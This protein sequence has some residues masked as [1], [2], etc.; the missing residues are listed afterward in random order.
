MGTRMDKVLNILPL[1][2]LVA[3]ADDRITD[4]NKFVL[5]LLQ[6]RESEVIQVKRLRDLLPM[7]TRIYFET[8]VR[9]L[10]QMHGTVEEIS[11]ELV[12]KDSLP[13][14][15]LM[16]AVVSKDGADGSDT[17]QYT[18]FDI[19]H[20]KKYETELLLA[21]QKQAGLIAEL[22]E[23]N[24]K[25]LKT[26]QELRHKKNIYKNQA[27]TYQQISEVGRVGGWT[28]NLVTGK[29]HWSDVMRQIHEVP[30]DFEPDLATA[31]YFYKEGESRNTVQAALGEAIKNGI[32]SLDLEAQLVTAQGKQIWVR[33]RVQAER[34]VGKTIQLAR[35]FRHLAGAG[36]TDQTTVRLYGTF[37]DI[38]KEKKLLLQLQKTNEQIQKDAAYYKS[39]IEN[40][41]F[42][43][44]KTDMSGNCT[45][46]NSL[47]C[48][49]LGIGA[50]D[51]LGR[52]SMELLLSEDHG[53]CLETV[54]KCMAQPDTIHW[55][56]LRKS[57]PRGTITNQWEFKLLI[58]EQGNPVEF[59]C[60]GHEITH[61]IQKQQLL[62]TQIVT[63]RQ[64]NSRLQNF[65]HII[66]HNIR[67]HVANLTGI[68]DLTDMADEHDRQQSFG[69]MKST[70][71]ALDE[72][73]QHL[74]EIIGIQANIDLPLKLIRV[75]ETVDKVSQGIRLMIDGAKASI[76]CD[77]DADAQLLVNHAYFESIL[78]NLLT[79][80]IKYRSPARNP[81]ITIS[82]HCEGN[83]QVLSVRDNGSGMDLERYRDKVFGLYKTFH[84][85]RDAKG[86]GLFMTKVQVEAMG[87]TIEVESEFHTGTTFKLY[88]NNG[89]S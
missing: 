67:S 29:L 80:A 58:D 79:N 21:N 44:I 15:V 59:L 50:A 43:I 12:R 51:Y 3:A 54:R 85:N 30:D 77:F 14:P 71:A 28:L 46:V 19:S 53:A 45:F 88:F 4:A 18:F 42:Y 10:L 52:S 72:T 37:Q 20:R 82:L 62:E 78:L 35:E 2:Y 61:L 34:S 81:Q 6:M 25:Y 40:N 17:V 24:R 75:G 23:L 64:Q 68:I 73:I 31:L 32:H 5:D 66:S 87:G 55:V 89:E 74:N 27:A 39:T 9:P 84:G 86:M 63:I 47:L 76:R 26:A 22:G 65:T 57:T 69:L 16:N 41:S 1:G 11:M 33:V 8:H 38:D 36:N 60:I 48:E 49:M 83:R 13:V 70:V 7:G 56:I